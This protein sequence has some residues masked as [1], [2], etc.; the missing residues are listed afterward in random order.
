VAAWIAAAAALAGVAGTVVTSVVSSRNTVKATKYTAEAGTASTMA[1]LAAA[2]E[3][4][5]WEKRAAVYEETLS[6]LLHRQAK[7][8]HDLR[9]Y[10]LD[11]E[12][13]RRLADFYDSYE[14]T[15][16]F[17]IYGRLVAY[18]SEPVL[19]AYEASQQAHHE[20][21]ARCQHRQMLADEAKMA[22][23]TGRPGTAQTGTSWSMPARRST[24]RS[25]RLRP[26]TRRSSK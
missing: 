25:K 4:R 1:T 18:A 14:A 23:E 15:G 22:Q 11:E 12:S 3:D 21:R 7:R 8:R 20:V 16:M 10:R 26:W 5:L 2:R 19:D 9:G 13:E 24:G 6:G 17:E